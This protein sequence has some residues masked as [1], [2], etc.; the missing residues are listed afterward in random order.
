M[1]NVLAQRSAFCWGYL[2][3]RS[4][5]QAHADLLESSVVA[6]REDLEHLSGQF[7]LL[8]EELKASFDSMSMQ[9]GAVVS[10]VQEKLEMQ[11]FMKDGMSLSP[12]MEATVLR[13]C[14]QIRSHHGRYWM[15]E[16]TAVLS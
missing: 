6:L 8:Q 2:D 11:P 4:S 15:T 7:L 5:W 10:W 1:A 13:C 16:S 9:L 14:D 3:L 12:I